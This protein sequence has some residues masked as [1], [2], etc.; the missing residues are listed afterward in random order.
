MSEMFS[1]SL[2]ATQIS[3]F[4]AALAVYALFSFL[5][6]SVTAL[7]LFKLKEISRTTDGY[8]SLINSIEHNPRRVLITILIMSTLA[9]VVAANVFEK[10][11]RSTLDVGGTFSILIAGALT[12]IAIAIFGEILP[13]N[14]AQ[15][16]GENLFKSTLWITNIFYYLC[17]P[18]ATLLIKVSNK[19]ESSI[20]IE[21]SNGVVTETEIR[22]LI[23]TVKKKGVIEPEKLNMLNSIFDLGSTKVREIMVPGTQMWSIKVDTTVDQAMSQFCKYQF[24][25]VPVYKDRQDNIV[26]MLHLKDLLFKCPVDQQKEFSVEG[27]L[28]P[29]L[30]TNE[31]IKINQLLREFRQERMHIAIVLN[32]FGSVVGLVTLEDVLEEIVGDIQDEYE[33][34][35]IKPIVARNATEWIVQGSAN[36]EDLY[37]DLGLNFDK[38]D[39]LTLS[40]FLTTQLQRLPQKDDNLVYEGYIFTVEKATKKRVLSVL[41][42]KMPSNKDKD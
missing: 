11:V 31:H 2:L 32:E 12:T 1:Y 8:K 3:I 36:L 30:F 13:K 20:G 10:I 7:R 16:Y 17:Y 15:A 27:L 34:T 4:V 39:A 38:F 14:F 33:S 35:I 37:D 41:I 9:G 22:F 19:M 21:E 6:T 18:F 26:G 28:R 42:K 23:D 29:I 5:E 24:S 25:R 40:G